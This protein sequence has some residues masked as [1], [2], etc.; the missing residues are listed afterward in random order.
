MSAVPSPTT[1]GSSAQQQQ[2][3]QPPPLR[4]ALKSDDDIERP[5][6]PSGSLK[7]RFLKIFFVTVAAL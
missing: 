4:S 5:L 6:P 3:P 2:Q 1:N 7:G